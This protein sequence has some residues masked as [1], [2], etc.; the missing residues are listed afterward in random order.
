LYMTKSGSCNSSGNTVYSS[1]SR[2]NRLPDCDITLV[3]D[4]GAEAG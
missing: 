1:F 3:C 4:T 2:L